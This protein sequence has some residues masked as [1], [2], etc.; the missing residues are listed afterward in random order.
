MRIAIIGGRYKNEE[1]LARTAEEA[2]YDLAFHE[3]H[4]HGGV[5]ELRSIVQRSQLVVIVTDVNSHGAVHVA[6][7]YA[8]QHQR[9]TLI[10]RSFGVARL[11]QLILALEARRTNQHPSAA[12]VAAAH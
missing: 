1:A 6:K 5:D 7:K 10:L 9:A 11:K 8:R 12:S 4:L 3:G 2:G